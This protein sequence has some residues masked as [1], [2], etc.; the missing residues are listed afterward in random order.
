M[1]VC[2]TPRLRLRHLTEDDAAFIVQLLNDPGF[3]RNIGDRKVRT[4]DEARRY[5]QSDT[6]SG[7]GRR[8]YGLYLV[9]RKEDAAP[10]GVCGL[11]KRDYLPDMDVGFAFLQNFHGRGYGLESARAVLRHARAALG[12]P[13][14][15][16]ITSPGNEASIRL[17][18]KLGLRFERMIRPPDED[19]DTRLFVPGNE[20]CSE[21]HVPSRHE[22]RAD[23]K[24]E[25]G[26]SGHAEAGRSDR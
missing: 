10:I 13:R 20:P 2:E 15:V 3:I 14:V 21:A 5:I 25:T 4:I 26:G 9:E 6:V 18:G 1:I 17:L 22:E 7:Y 24:A 12:I 11:L 23:E 16:A 19:R 8:G